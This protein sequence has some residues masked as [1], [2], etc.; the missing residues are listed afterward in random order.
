MGRQH[1][2]WGGVHQGGLEDGRAIP[3]FP[4]IVL[5]VRGVG[6]CGFGTAPGPPAGIGSWRGKSW[7]AAL[8][9]GATWV[10]SEPQRFAPGGTA[11]KALA[12][13]LRAIPLFA[14]KIDS[15]ALVGRDDP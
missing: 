4:G 1:L 3:I 5:K 6:K 8:E 15:Y 9:G 11:N 13:G 10:R 2:G 7:P 14:R 12:I